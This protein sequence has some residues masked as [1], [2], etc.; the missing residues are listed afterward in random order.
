MSD[1]PLESMRAR[2]AK[3]RWLAKEMLDRQ[4]KQALLEMAEEIERDIE[5]LEAERKGRPS[6]ASNT[7]AADLPN[8]TI[9]IR[10]E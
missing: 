5:K 4:T 10:P 8:A 6:A 3:C 9:K 7:P 2:A 1:D